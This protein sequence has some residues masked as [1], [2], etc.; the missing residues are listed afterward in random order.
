MLCNL[1]GKIGFEDIFAI[2][3]CKYL[4]HSGNG[5]FSNKHSKN[6][7]LYS[8]LASWHCSGVIVRSSKCTRCGNQDI[9]N[10]LYGKNKVYANI[11]LTIDNS[12]E[13]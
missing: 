1:L 11:T 2:F 10:N 5:A 7:L 13:K 8:L 4:R 6:G 9:I 12:I 3:L